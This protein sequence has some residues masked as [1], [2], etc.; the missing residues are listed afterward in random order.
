MFIEISF[1]GDKLLD[2]SFG[3]AFVDSEGMEWF[4]KGV[5]GTDGGMEEVVEEEVVED[6]LEEEVEEAGL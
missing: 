2:S 5:D 6:E 4:V 1:S 3:S